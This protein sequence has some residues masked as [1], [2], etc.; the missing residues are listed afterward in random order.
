MVNYLAAK[1]KVIKIMGLSQPI[2]KQ[3]V[4]KVEK[5]RRHGVMIR[6][7]ASHAPL[8]YILTDPGLIYLKHSSSLFKCTKKAL[9]EAQA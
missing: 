3:E 6:E 1:A 7:A 9:R 4:T 2:Y 5:V 8:H